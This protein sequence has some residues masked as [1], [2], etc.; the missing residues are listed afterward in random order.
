MHSFRRFL[1]LMR[2]ANGPEHLGVT[3]SAEPICEDGWNPSRPLELHAV[4]FESNYYSTNQ[5]M[6]PLRQTT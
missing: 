4:D 2:I 3:Y 6:T 1:M 5:G